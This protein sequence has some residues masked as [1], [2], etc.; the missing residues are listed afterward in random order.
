MELREI[1][2]LDEPINEALSSPSLK[3][4]MFNSPEEVGLGEELEICSIDV[5]VEL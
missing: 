4:I 3:L 5:K 1:V 2:P